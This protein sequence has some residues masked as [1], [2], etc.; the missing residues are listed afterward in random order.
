[1]IHLINKALLGRLPSNGIYLV[2]IVGSTYYYPFCKSN[3]EAS[4]CIH[5]ILRMS[6]LKAKIPFF[7]LALL[8]L[9]EFGRLDS[10]EALAVERH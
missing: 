5:F 6:I 10:L 4:R 3:T 9:Y 8:L 2:V 1:M 7:M